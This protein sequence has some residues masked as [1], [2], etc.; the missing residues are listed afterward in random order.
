MKKLI[1]TLWLLFSTFL[2]IAQ[3]GVITLKKNESVPLNMWYT[4]YE[5]GRED[6]LYITFDNEDLAVY[7]LDNLLGQ[8]D[9][10]IELPND[11]DVDGDPYWTVEQENGYISDIYYIKE[12]NYSLYTITIVSA[13]GGE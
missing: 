3:I 9:M 10:E 1:L 5:K 6:N 2:T 13:W 11:K 12:K 8:F 7:T 4:I